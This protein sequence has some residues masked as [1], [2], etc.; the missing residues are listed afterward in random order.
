MCV[1]RA[2]GDRHPCLWA[3]M[4]SSLPHQR[5][6]GT[7]AL[8]TFVNKCPSHASPR[9]TMCPGVHFSFKT[10]SQ[11]FLAFSASFATFSSENNPPS[12]THTKHS[13]PWHTKPSCMPAPWVTRCCFQL[14]LVGHTRLA[15]MY[16]LLH[17]RQEISATQPA[18]QVVF[19]DHSLFGF[20]ELGSI[21][22]NK[23]LKFTL[24]DVHHVI[25]V[26]HTSKENTV[27]RAC[28]PPHRVSVIPNGMACCVWDWDG[29]DS[30]VNDGNVYSRSHIRVWGGVCHICTHTHTYK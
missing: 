28:L 8:I 19:T 2:G 29:V 1:H 10:L 20:A 30:W 5:P 11:R 15:H 22:M 23:V 4:R 9:C 17:P 6:Q 13:P 16:C 14:K 25:C 18:L 24:S 7:H 26:S 3:K 27:L 12:C 21:L